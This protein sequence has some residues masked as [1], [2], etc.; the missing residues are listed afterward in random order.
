MDIW[1]HY[2]QTDHWETK[3]ILVSQNWKL[4]NSGLMKKEDNMQKIFLQNLYTEFYTQ[5]LRVIWGG[6]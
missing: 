4:K 3:N 5:K 2:S 1:G 6:K